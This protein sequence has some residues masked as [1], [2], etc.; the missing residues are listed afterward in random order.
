MIEE[1]DT[2]KSLFDGFAGFIMVPKGILTDG[3]I[4]ARAHALGIPAHDHPVSIVQSLAQPSPLVRLP[5]SQASPFTI[6]PS[7]QIGIQELG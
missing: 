6:K 4:A 5:S 3:G 2:E 7:P 1:I